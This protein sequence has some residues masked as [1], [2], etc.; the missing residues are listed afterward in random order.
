MNRM[1][2]FIKLFFYAFQVMCN[3]QSFTALINRVDRDDKKVA[4]SFTDQFFFFAPDIK[5]HTLF[6]YV[7]IYPSGQK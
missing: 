6:Y 3:S 1:R 5:L 4:F 2:S 7:N